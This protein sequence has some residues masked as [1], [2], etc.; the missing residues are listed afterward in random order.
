MADKGYSSA[1]NRCDLEQAGYFDLIMYKVSRPGPP[2]KRGTRDG[3]PSISRLR[4]S[5]ERAFGSMK[6]H[7]GLNRARHLGV[8]KMGM[9]LMLSAM[10]F[11]LKKAALLAG[12]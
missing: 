12:G 10:A 6:T 1:D 4:G 9:Q 7:Y 8:A 3:E 11:N 5:V 2:S